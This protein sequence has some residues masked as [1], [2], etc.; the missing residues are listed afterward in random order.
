MPSSQLSASPSL[1][2]DTADTATVQ[3]IR[4]AGFITV[5]EAQ[6]AADDR[7]SA[8]RELAASTSRNALLLHDITP[9]AGPITRQQRAADEARQQIADKI[10]ALPLNSGPRA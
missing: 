8:M 3:A 4:D 9:D 5:D 7:V 2:L 10:M 1:T 6:A